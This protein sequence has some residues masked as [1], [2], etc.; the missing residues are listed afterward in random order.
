MF[1]INSC[2]TEDTQQH[3]TRHAKTQDNV[4]SVWVFYLNRFQSGVI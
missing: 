2:L 4:V 3:A 1:I